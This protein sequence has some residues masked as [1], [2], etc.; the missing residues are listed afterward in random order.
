MC[1]VEKGRERRGAFPREEK[2]EGPSLSREE[3]REGPSL[4]R[5]ERREERG[6]GPPLVEKRREKRGA[7]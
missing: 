2:R 3:K 7:S 6:E 4:S 5:E 1:S